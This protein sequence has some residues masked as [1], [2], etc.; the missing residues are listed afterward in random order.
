MCSH[1]ESTGS[2][3]W[4]NPGWGTHSFLRFLAKS[5]NQIL[6]SLDTVF[7]HKEHECLDGKNV[8]GS[9]QQRRHLPSCNNCPLPHTADTEPSC[10]GPRPCPSDDASHVWASQTLKPWHWEKLGRAVSKALGDTASEAGAGTLLVAQCQG[11]EK[12]GE[13]GDWVWG[14]K[15]HG[16]SQHEITSCQASLF[17]GQ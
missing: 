5:I 12:G 15:Y 10:R 4:Q 3:H 13:G 17:W 7:W 1:A 2:C 9:L 6:L 11:R 14:N 16:T 8:S